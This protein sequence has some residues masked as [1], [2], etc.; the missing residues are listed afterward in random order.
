MAA[1]LPALT[2]TP[3]HYTPYIHLTSF[4]Y[5]HLIGNYAFAFPHGLKLPVLS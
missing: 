1:K 4:F 2:L 3:F 5:R